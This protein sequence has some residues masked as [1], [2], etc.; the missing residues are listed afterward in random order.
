MIVIV[1]I[2]TTFITIPIPLTKGQFNIGDVGVFISGIFFGPLVGG[3]AGGVGSA[4][5]DVFS[6]YVHYAPITFLVKGLEGFLT[7]L[8]YHYG[9]MRKNQNREQKSLKEL[10]QFDIWRETQKNEL[11]I[12]HTLGLKIIGIIAGA[13]VMVLGYYT[14]Q[15]FVY[16]PEA[17]LLEILPNI[18]QVS[19]GLIFAVIITQTIEP[20]IKKEFL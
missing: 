17:A 4:L 14:Y 9:L 8:V 12:K 20:I 6:G 13:I 3:I 10:L 1:A 18:T 11:K 19:L 2:F 5:G 15:Y 16:G 7:G